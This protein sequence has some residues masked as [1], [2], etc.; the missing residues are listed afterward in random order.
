MAEVALSS[1]QT[2]WDDRIS[3]I[4]KALQKIAEIELSFQGWH[5]SNGVK[6]MKDELVSLKTFYS[7]LLVS[8]FCFYL[9]IINIT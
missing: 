4:H 8:S 2:R 5:E 7:F 3:A 9:I 6:I 1:S